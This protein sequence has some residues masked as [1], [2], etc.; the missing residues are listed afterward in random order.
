MRMHITIAA[1][2]CACQLRRFFT[3]NSLLENY[4]L[5]ALPRADDPWRSLNSRSPPRYSY[6]HDGDFPPEG[7]ALKDAIEAPDGIPFVSPE[8]NRSVPG[9]LKNAIDWGPRRRGHIGDPQPDAQKLSR[10]TGSGPPDPSMQNGAR[11]RQ[12]CRRGAVPASN[13]KGR[14]SSYKVAL[15]SRNSAIASATIVALSAPRTSI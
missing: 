9:A 15:A 10:W 4:L 2:V 6:D 14:T 12:A 7:R 11:T 5:S 13:T 1:S 8:Y 3:A